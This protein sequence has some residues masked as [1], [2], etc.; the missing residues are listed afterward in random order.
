M[1]T[2]PVL[3]PNAQ[4]Q[5]VPELTW[6]QRF[7]HQ[8][9]LTFR[10]GSTYFV[11]GAGILW[12][13]FRTMIPEAD[14]LRLIESIPI[15]KGW[16]PIIIMVGGFIASRAKPSTAVSSQTRAML[17]EIAQLRMAEWAR[18]QGINPA[19]LP[20]SVKPSPAV[21]VPPVPAVASDHPFAAPPSPPPGPINPEVMQKAK[22]IY[23]LVEML[24]GERKPDL[25]L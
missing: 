25:T 8:L 3:V 21:A 2:T 11:V 19:T 22:E 20:A 16:G 13:A 14:Q 12:G 5:L 23:A 17:D 7:L 18:S 10:S 1:T 4:G 9:E 15:L 24:R 6:Q